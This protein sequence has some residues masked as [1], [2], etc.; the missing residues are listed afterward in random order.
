MRTKRAFVPTAL[1]RLE[2][3]AVPAPT[4]F[5]GVAVLTRQVYNNAVVGIVNSFNIFGRTQNYGQLYNNLTRS[6]RSIPYH[7]VDGLDNQMLQIVWQLNANIHNQVPFSVI[8]ARQAAI[9]AL[10]N[11]VAARVAS[12][13][14][15]F[16]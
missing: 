13:T 3:R 9:S 2:D 4:F 16:V 14:V 12:G 11:D 15:L 10:N 5:N 7:H 6:I 1:S 8:G